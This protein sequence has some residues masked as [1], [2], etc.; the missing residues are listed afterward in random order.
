[1]KVKKKS[2]ER[3][4]ANIVFTGEGFSLNLEFRNFL[5]SQ[6]MDSVLLQVS[7]NFCVHWRN[8]YSKM[9]YMNP[10]VKEAVFS[11]VDSSIQNRLKIKCHICCF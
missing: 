6:E 9:T 10:L 2:G 8:L 11:E 7:Q 4:K 5:C 3:E 1:M